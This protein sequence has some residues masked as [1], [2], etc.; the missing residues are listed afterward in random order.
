M[1]PLDTIAAIATPGG[2]GGIGI[3]RLSGPAALSIAEAIVE[4]SLQPRHAHFCHCKQDG[5]TIDSG[6]VL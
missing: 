6:I 2:H 1:I 4:V 3:I 5:K